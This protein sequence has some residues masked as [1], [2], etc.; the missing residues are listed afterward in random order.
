MMRIAIGTSR[1]IAPEVCNLIV[2]GPEEEYSQ[3]VDMWAL[4]AIAYE[5]MTGSIPFCSPAPTNKTHRTQNDKDSAG[6]NN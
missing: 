5:I 1:Y 6:I 2:L 4:G 3:A